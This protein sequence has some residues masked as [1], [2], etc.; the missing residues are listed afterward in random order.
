M[1]ASFSAYLLDGTSRAPVLAEVFD[2]IS[3]ADLA[4]WAATWRPY[5][6][7]I[8]SDLDR[9]NV[10]MSARPQSGHWNWADKAMVTSILAKKGF[11]IRCNGELQGM[12]I[13]D[14]V[15]KRCR[16]L[17]QA[18]KELV[19]VD[20]VEAA[21]WNQVAISKPPRFTGVGS[22]LIAAAIRLSDDYGFKGRVGLH[23]LP[24]ADRWYKN[25]L[26]MVDQGVDH[27]YSGGPLRYFE[28]TP[29]VAKAHL[30]GVVIP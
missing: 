2:E 29:D 24:Q 6:A 9:R 20:Y 26:G 18:G 14:V 11:A 17:E 27:G 19:Y 12:M 30:N 25:C 7:Q 3:D 8:V 23:S 5:F 10:P 4:D 28:M 15:S 22:V 16:A 21:P 1:T 13:V